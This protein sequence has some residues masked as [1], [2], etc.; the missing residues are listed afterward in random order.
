[1][2]QGAVALSIPEPL[3]KVQP[4]DL[5]WVK[6]TLIQSLEPTWKGPYP[7]VLTTPTGVKVASVIPQLHYTKLR[8]LQRTKIDGLS[9]DLP[10]H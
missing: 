4:V 5:V 9:P 8:R 6:R 1:M 10:T 7:V 2:V 3:H